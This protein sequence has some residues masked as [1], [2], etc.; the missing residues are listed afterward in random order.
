[1]ILSFKLSYLEK[2]F[3]VY[4]LFSIDSITSLISVD[5]APGVLLGLSSW[6]QSVFF[7]SPDTSARFARVTLLLYTKPIL[8]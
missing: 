3:M 6:L 2:V 8:R 5:S 4:V 7:L 1:M